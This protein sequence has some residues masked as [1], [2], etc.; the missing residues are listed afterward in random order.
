MLLALLLAGCGDKWVVLGE[1]LDE[2]LLHIR[3]DDDGSIWAIGADTGDGPAVYVYDAG[4]WD[5]LETGDSGDL[6]W[7]WGDA[8]AVWM[9]G[10]GGRVVR[11][12]K[13]EETFETTVLDSNMVFFGIWGMSADD[14]WVVGGDVDGGTGVQI[15]TG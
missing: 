9:V 15:W 4:A 6:W 10:E 12:D 8:D 1:D 7:G 3:Q 11:Y 2:S 14:M 13:A 5:R